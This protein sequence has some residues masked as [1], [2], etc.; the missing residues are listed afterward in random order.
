VYRVPEKHLDRSEFQDAIKKGMGRAVAH[1]RAC[2]DAA[3]SDDILAACIN[4]LR[5]DR[6]IERSRVDYLWT[7]IS[8]TDDAARYGTRLCQALTEATDTWNAIQLAALVG[9]F[10]LAGDS[11]ARQVLLHTLERSAFDE[12][13]GS[14]EIMLLD[15]IDGFLWMV[16]RH[17]KR[18]AADHCNR[19]RIAYLAPFF[20][21]ACK[22]FGEHQVLTALSDRAATAPNARTYLDAV[23]SSWLAEEKRD[24]QEEHVPSVDEVL[25]DIE[26]DRTVHWRFPR[27]ASDRDIETIFE[28]LLVEDRPRQLVQM[29]RIF[30]KREVPRLDGRLFELAEHED[31][32]VRRVA[33]SALARSDDLWVRQFALSLL[34]RRPQS[35]G[36]GAIGL[37]FLRYQPADHEVIEQALPAPDDAYGRHSAGLDVVILA[38]EYADPA[39]VPSLLWVYEHGPSSFSRSRTVEALLKMDSAPPWMLKECLDDCYDRTR[40]MAQNALGDPPQR[41]PL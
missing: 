41:P 17:G 3:V 23:K 21:R 1:V 28:R 20:W 38:E 31:P 12:M 36:E 14:H 25:C 16:E 27:K 32:T 24:R 33:I 37:L 26:A 6:Q 19:K 18:L 11:A 2:G 40:E 4:D 9:E 34:Q 10:A 29:L 15:G 7:M 5:Y 8:L 39:L 13:V 30:A 35:A 22:L